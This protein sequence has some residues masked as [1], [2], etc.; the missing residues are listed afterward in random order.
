MEDLKNIP[1]HVEYALKG[2]QQGSWG[3]FGICWEWAIEQDW[4][5][6]FL[7]EISNISVD[8]K[9]LLFNS[10]IISPT[11]FANAI[12]EFLKGRE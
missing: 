2:S 12:Y 7:I 9:C 11:T 8:S 5:D 1:T 6:S 4:W 3:A 10:S